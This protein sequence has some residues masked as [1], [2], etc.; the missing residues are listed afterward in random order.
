[1]K[2]EDVL[3]HPAY[4]F[5]DVQNELYSQVVDYMDREK[6]NRSELAK[7]LKVSKGYVSQI[8]NG[9]YNYTLKKWIELCLAIGIVPGVYRKLDDVIEADKEFARAKKDAI[10]GETTT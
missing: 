4:W 7:R 5:E 6:I 1:M 2:R 3:R 10:R 8:L 9:N